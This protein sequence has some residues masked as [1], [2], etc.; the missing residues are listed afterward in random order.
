MLRSTFYTYTV[1]SH[2]HGHKLKAPTSARR[3]LLLR[4][5][6]TPGVATFT[7]TGPEFRYT[8]ESGRERYAR[9]P[10]TV[11]LADQSLQYWAIGDPDSP[12]ED[13]RACRA[14]AARLGRKHIAIPDTL[15]LN[16]VEFSNR[17][18]AHTLLYQG[19]QFRTQD[20]ESKAL[21]ATHRR[22]RTLGE[23]A[24]EVRL[25][26]TQMKVVFLRAWLRK[27]VEWDIT[28]TPL[29]MSLEVMQ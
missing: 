16:P 1:N 21:I 6:T 3:D 7:P 11:V 23:L 8:D 20:A 13:L 29:S 27:R 2:I 12:S 5:V 10:L 18:E 19:R 4:V 9:I 24:E 14:Q 15:A 17:W 28:A 26:P 22:R 25:S